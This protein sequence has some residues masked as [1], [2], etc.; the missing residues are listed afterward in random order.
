MAIYPYSGTN[1]GTTDQ[2]L[3]DSFRVI[4]DVHDNLAAI[5][6]V[7]LRSTS[8]DALL[9]EAE[10]NA[11]A[12][13]SS[14][15]AAGLSAAAA[16]GSA[17]T[18]STAS[19]TATEQAS[20][21]TTKAI[22]VAASVTTAT[23]Q[24]TSATTQAGIA[25]TQAGIATTQATSATT[26]AG[27][28]TTQAGIATTARNLAQ[29]WAEGNEPGGVGTKS[30]KL[31]AELAASSSTYAA[32]ALDLTRLSLY[33][34]S[35]DK[36]ASLILEFKP[37]QYL[38]AENPGLGRLLIMSK[39]NTPVGPVLT[40]KSFRQLIDFTRTSSATYVDATGKI[41][42][43]PQS[44]NLLTFTQ[45]FNN[46][47]WVK[48]NAT[49]TA[50]STVAPDGT[51]TADTLVATAGTAA[52]SINRSGGG[53]GAPIA[54]SVYAKAG[55]SSFIQLF[56]GSA[57]TAYAN[58]NLTTGVVGTVGAGA[59][60]SISPA[61][62]GWYRC[63]I[64]FTPGAASASRITIVSSGT[65]AYNESWTAAGTETIFIW[66]AQ[67]EA[68]STATD[69]TRNVGGL[70]P[71]RFDY[72]PV[73]LAP[74]GLLIEEQ[75]TN[76]LLRSE[77]FDNESWTKTGATVTANST[78]AP[79][80]ATTADT[81]TSSVSV[82]T[83]TQTVTFT[84][85]GSKSASLFLRAGTA[86]T[87]FFQIRDTT[88]SATRGS[89]TITWIAGVPSAVAGSGGTIE[90]V[91][92]FGNGWYR[93]KLIC[94]GVV[95]ANTNQFRIQPDS[96]TG[97]GSVIAWGAQ[98][99]EGSFATS[100]IPTAASQVTRTLDVAA[101][102]GANFSQWF[103]A[104]SG[105][106]L[107]EFTPST[108]SGTRTVAAINDNT[109]NESIHIRTIS[110]DPFFTVT[111]G[112]VVQANLDAGSIA[113]GTTYK[114]AGAYALN[115]FAVSING[116][117]VVAGTSGTLPTVTQLEMGSLA[118]TNFLNGH[119]RSIKYF[120]TRLSNTQLQALTA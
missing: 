35:L 111:D 85:N 10:A 30:A 108:V 118:S 23:T 67:L 98:L 47:A 34:G 26:Q 53:S 93:V 62:N 19:T 5:N 58:F 102:T 96:G 60:A 94:A 27:I 101:I 66:G 59:T 61:G 110:A 64:V 103:N 73:T 79:D 76:L 1:D 25:T 71:P 54:F 7:A 14:A 15:T 41:A 84:S 63:S 44:R 36:D 38:G 75:R 106:L 89:A 87:T 99:E 92:N 13:V 17:S 88:A 97:T 32:I 80:G 12:A 46:A 55:T 95:A 107:T 50:N 31:W 22:E 3:G 42:L 105:T 56:H 8:I 57:S 18:A 91:E 29:A 9:A 113:A 48:L 45:E 100:Y 74:K 86:G 69:Y 83:V 70:F 68:G 52:H 112:G 16:A 40:T 82:D 114:I 24:A 116:G 72:D 28:A 117:S 21:A 109:S 65:A 11:N 20:V 49:I 39:E 90:G 4:K 6:E 119:I 115:D 120:P 77:E 78:V 104:A 37:P 33:G 81:L 2:I 43:T 51:M